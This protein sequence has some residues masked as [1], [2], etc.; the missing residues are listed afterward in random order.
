MVA[1]RLEEY[2]GV[3]EELEGELK[4]EKEKM[5]PFLHNNLAA[6]EE[7]ILSEREEYVITISLP[8]S[9]SLT[10]ASSLEM[11]NIRETEWRNGVQ[12]LTLIAIV[13][14]LAFQVP[15]WLAVESR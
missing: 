3:V 5:L 12:D 10:I 6:N 7:R 11:P 9:L 4:A 14:F 8:L 13:N 2:A 15:G 1:R